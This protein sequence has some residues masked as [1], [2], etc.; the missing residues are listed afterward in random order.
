MPL[1]NLLI[2]DHDVSEG[3]GYAFYT[4]GCGYCLL[5]LAMLYRV[6]SN[7]LQRQHKCLEAPMMLTCGLM[8]YTATRGTLLVVA[9]ADHILRHWVRM[10]PHVLFLCLI[11]LLMYTWVRFVE[12]LRRIYLVA[13]SDADRNLLL[14]NAVAVGVVFITLVAAVVPLGDPYVTDVLIIAN[15]VA[16]LVCGLV[17]VVLILVLT[18]RISAAYCRDQRTHAPFGT[19]HDTPIFADGSNGPSS[20]RYTATVVS[21][22][23][24]ESRRRLLVDSEANL[25]SPMDRVSSAPS[26][27]SQRTTQEDHLETLTA[28]EGTPCC[29]SI[30]DLFSEEARPWRLLVAL[31]MLAIYCVVRSLTSLA[32]LLAAI[33]LSHTSVVVPL[34]LGFYGAKLVLLICSVV[35]LLGSPDD[36]P[37]PPPLEEG[38]IHDTG[39]RG[40]VVSS[41]EEQA[42]SS[43]AQSDPPQSVATTLGD[44]GGFLTY[45]S[46]LSTNSSTT[47]TPSLTSAR[48]PSLSS[49]PSSSSVV[50]SGVRVPGAVAGRGRRDV[51]SSYRA[52]NERRPQTVG[53]APAVIG[54]DSLAAQ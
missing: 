41:R 9:G 12:Q 2:S 50:V 52:S 4:I 40:A 14:I 5:S 31:R 21:E 6:L 32:T 27:P 23:W 42:V 46:T 37:A 26:S 28:V 11:L 34:M 18:S 44:T 1:G 38:N 17:T 24:G 13:A 16:D 22:I 43:L 53:S 36:T 19:Q 15:T 20:S 51:S 10:A 39:A 45:P 25:S 30:R 8:A 49:R 47:T 48:S 7:L 3:E 33:Y 29:A 35:V 54:S